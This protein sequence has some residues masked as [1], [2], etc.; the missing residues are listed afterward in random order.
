MADKKPPLVEPAGSSD[1][2]AAGWIAHAIPAALG[3]AAL[4]AAVFSQRAGIQSTLMV[5]LLVGGGLLIALSYF[6]VMRSR[7]AWSFVISLSVVLAIMTLFGAP[8]I[9]TLV[10]IHMAVAL[11]IPLLFFVAAG[12]LSTMGP[13]YN[14]S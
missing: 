11:V 6:S 14:K 9:R 2:D 3:V 1:L 8:K 12:M 10:G 4:I 7:A 13:R 5:S